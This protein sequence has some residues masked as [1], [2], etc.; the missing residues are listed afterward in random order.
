MSMTPPISPLI[1]RRVATAL[2]PRPLRPPNPPK[3]SPAPPKKSLGEAAEPL[4]AAFI[5]HV[6]GGTSA[7]EHG[8]GRQ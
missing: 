3:M 1:D 4:E 6:W 5:G 2:S 8:T 7:D